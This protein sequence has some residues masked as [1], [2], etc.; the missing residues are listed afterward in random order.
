MMNVQTFAIGPLPTNAYLVTCTDTGQALLIDPGW[1]DR[2]LEA[3]LT[4]A[5]VTHIVLTHAHWDHIGGVALAHRLT[6]API[7]IHSE[8]APM[9]EAGG[10]ASSMNL[11]LEPSPPPDLTLTPDDEVIVGGLNFRVLFTPGHAPGHISLYSEGAQA[12]F[13]GDVLFRS[14]VGRTD[15][16]GGS[17][18]QLI[19]AIT[20]Q[21]MPLPD[22]V[23]V[24]PG[25]GPTTT[26]GTER[27][28]NPFL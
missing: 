18:D 7:A 22:E 3:A 24:Y 20:T 25:H 19:T 21:L 1:P 6:G 15:L 16:P 10:F 4:E 13:V 27:Q 14:G 11:K 2:Q 8:A 17:H 28:F 26:I 5:E 23:T 12:A 9:L